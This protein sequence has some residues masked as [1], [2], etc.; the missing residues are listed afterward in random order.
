MRRPAHGAIADAR[1]RLVACGV[2]APLAAGEL[3][4]SRLR[5][6][7]VSLLLSRG[8]AARAPAGFVRC[9]APR[10]PAPAVSAVSQASMSSVLGLQHDPARHPRTPRL[11]PVATVAHAAR[12]A[13]RRPRP[14]SCAR[15]SGRT[16]P[17]ERARRGPRLGIASSSLAARL[18]TKVAEVG[19]SRRAATPRAGRARA[20]LQT[21]YGE[22]TPPPSLAHGRARDASRAAAAPVPRR[23]SLDRNGAL[24]SGRR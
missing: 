11:E 6:P 16:S 22:P 2:A 20:V 13:P 9:A 7:I 23:S 10:P 14:R 1:P 15:P 19:L 24:R 4:S 18:S 8:A 3:P 21:P 12:A 17:G 5:N